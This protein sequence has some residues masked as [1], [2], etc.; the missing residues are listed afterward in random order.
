MTVSNAWG[1]FRPYSL[2]DFHAFAKN[3]AWLIE[4]PLHKSQELLARMY[5]YSSL[6]ELQQAMKKPGDAGFEFPDRAVVSGMSS[7]LTPEI[8]TRLLHMVAEAKGL[9]S[10]E[11]LPKRCWDVREIALYGTAKEHREA[12]RQVKG[13]IAVLAGEE[14][15]GGQPDLHDYAVVEV[16]AEGNKVVKF[17]V[18]GRHVFNAARELVSRDNLSN[19]LLIEQATKDLAQLAARHPRNPWVHA[20]KAV[21]L[22]EV[23]YVSGWADNLEA[24]QEWGF[25]L[26]ADPAFLRNEAADAARLLPAVKES[27]R[28]FE[29]LL[30]KNASVT[31][32]GYHYTSDD[33]GSE[34]LVSLL[35]WGTR[36]ASAAG[37][38]KLAVKWGRKY[39]KADRSD[40]SGVRFVLAP[41]YLN[42]GV[43][44][45]GSLFGKYTGGVA[46]LVRSIEAAKDADWK[47]A[48]QLFAKASASG[49][50]PIEAFTGAWPEARGGR[51]IGSNLDQ[52]A[53]YQEFMHRSAPFWDAN[54]A[55]K[56]FFTLVAN[57]DGFREAA[58]RTYG[59]W[60]QGWGNSSQAIKQDRDQAAQDLSEIG[61]RLGRA[62]G[63]R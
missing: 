3:L 52:P 13:P 15:E 14:Q 61:W 62:Y 47:K 9:E 28:L 36:V 55:L 34:T 44:G 25:D 27:F 7:M 31:S 16:S 49:Y 35:Y 40:R 33:A 37:D 48:G 18:L 58:L 54:P 24:S 29:E 39:R 12:F 23:S 17:T 42:L 5:G 21:G 6:H 8:G 2:A 1:H 26:D 41:L 38:Y 30:G 11:G 63:P 46:E 53:T 22:A 32:A 4:E 43:K 19:S 59:L 57:D 50:G 45:A 56:D 10:L 20:M 60:R 51:S